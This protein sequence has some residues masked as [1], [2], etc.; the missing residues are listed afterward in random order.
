MNGFDHNITKGLTSKS[1]LHFFALICLMQDKK[2]TFYVFTFSLFLA[3]SLLIQVKSKAQFV[4]ATLGI[5]GLTCSL[6]SYN[7]EQE[8]SKLEYVETI[9][10][11]LNQNIAQIKFAKGIPV[12]MKDVVNAVYKAGFSVG[13]T[14]AIFSFDSISITNN[15]FFVY[16][17]DT[18]LFVNK[19]TTPLKGEVALKFID[20]K[21]VEPNIYNFWE[22]QIRS[23]QQSSS[24]NT[25]VYHILL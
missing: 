1:I 21:F 20:K 11:D 2:C 18:Y 7:V 6:C 24:K 25:T 13:Y 8:I 4:S 19:V 5:N 12:H 10:M 23:S 15:N 9:K 17:N 3:C 22:K 14:Q 16:L